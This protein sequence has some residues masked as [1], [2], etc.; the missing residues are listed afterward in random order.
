MQGLTIEKLQSSTA[1]LECP[2]GHAPTKHRQKIPAHLIF[3]K[4]IGRTVVVGRKPTYLADVD[5]LSADHQARKL[6]VL[7]HA[8]A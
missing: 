5:L 6:H 4:R 2:L 8:L 3:A 7:Q 1:C